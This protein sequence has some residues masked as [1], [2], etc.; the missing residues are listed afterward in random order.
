VIFGFR[1]CDPESIIS[2]SPVQQLLVRAEYL[3]MRSEV[4]CGVNGETVQPCDPRERDVEAI[5]TTL[6]APKLDSRLFKTT[7]NALEVGQMGRVNNEIQIG[8]R[9][10]SKCLPAVKNTITHPCFIKSL[11]EPG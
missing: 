11:E 7:E 1:S 5:S 8:R 10:P 6:I 3:E 4:S 2:T 9:K